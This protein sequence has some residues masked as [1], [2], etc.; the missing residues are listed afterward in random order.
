LRKR[1]ELVWGR[2]VEKGNETLVERTLLI[3]IVLRMQQRMMAFLKRER[4]RK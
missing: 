1:V 4:E 2:W 3:E